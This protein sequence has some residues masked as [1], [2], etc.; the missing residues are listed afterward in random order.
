MQLVAAAPQLRSFCGGIGGPPRGLA[1]V[2]YTLPPCG[3]ISLFCSIRA[4]WQADIDAVA[5]VAALCAALTGSGGDRAPPVTLLSLRFCRLG[6]G[7]WAPLAAALPRCHVL[8][9]LRI[10][11][12]WGQGLEEAVALPRLRAA[13]AAKAP[14]VRLSV[15]VRDPDYS[16]E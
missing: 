14:P 13:A 6:E 7:G 9:E 5:S 10:A 2:L 4:L 3:N 11:D 15:S 12:G 16:D 8:V 1:A